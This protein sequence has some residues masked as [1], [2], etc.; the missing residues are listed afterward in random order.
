MHSEMIERMMRALDDELS[1]DEQQVL[2]A[3]T[4]SCVACADEWAALRAAHET[5]T[6]A[7][8]V[9]PSEG[10]AERVQLRVAVAATQKRSRW[11]DGLGVL[12][13]VGGVMVVSLW[14][15]LPLW[16]ALLLPELIAA[17]IGDMLSFS[18]IVSALWSWM[19]TAARVVGQMGGSGLWLLMVAAVLTL[20]ISWA[21]AVGGPTFF[22]VNVGSGNSRLLMLSL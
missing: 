20:M 18:Q 7:V 4:Q 13:F 14:A 16:Q 2:Q 15:V 9:A 19:T 5:L 12:L 11:L 6:Q 1:T 10:F 8:L 17:A 3:H 22:K 21:R